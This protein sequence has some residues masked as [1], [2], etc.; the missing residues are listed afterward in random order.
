VLAND[1]DAVT[2]VDALNAKV[3]DNAIIGKEQEATR[4]DNG[5][6]EVVNFKTLNE[7]T[8]VARTMGMKIGTIYMGVPADPAGEILKPALKKPCHLVEIGKNTVVFEEI[9][10]WSK[11]GDFKIN[12]HIIVT[13]DEHKF[14]GV[15][16]V[17]RPWLGTPQT[18]IPAVDMDKF[19]MP[20]D[21]SKPEE[22]QT[23]ARRVSAFQAVRRI[24]VMYQTPALK[25]I[26]FLNHP[27]QVYATEKIPK[28]GLV[29]VPNVDMNSVVKNTDGA[30][31]SLHNRC[32]PVGEHCHLNPPLVPKNPAE[33]IPGKTCLVPFWLVTTTDDKGAINMHM[34]CAKDKMTGLQIPYL[35][36][37]RVIQPREILYSGLERKANATLD[38][39]PAAKAKEKCKATESADGV[40]SKKRRVAA[41]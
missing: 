27:F 25:M 39:N 38:G 36:N 28:G 24:V 14:R 33:W 32:V 5:E 15:L 4:A 34:R 21:D 16:K 37:S 41:A 40:T 11:E 3:G 1:P 19:M 29:L 35:K 13:S 12:R 6:H 22:V 18:K 17:L 26:G 20:V 8:Y 7:S 2:M 31:Y 9:S 30:S 23:L 10:S